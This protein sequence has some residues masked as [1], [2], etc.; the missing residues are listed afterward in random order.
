M[1]VLTVGG[2][3]GGHVTPL[4]YVAS[5]LKKNDSNIEIVY[6]GPKNDRFNDLILSDKNFNLVKTIY[7]G[8]FR[9]YGRSFFA[10][11]TDVSTQLKNLLDLFK[12]S[13]GYVQSL[14]LLIKIKPDVIF[15][16]GSAT[17]VPISYA[18]RLLE[19]KL[20]THDSDHISGLAHKIAGSHATIN[21]VGQKNGN[22]PYPKQRIKYVG[23]PIN[24][25]FKDKPSSEDI[26]KT[27]NKY[28]LKE[29]FV[30][31]LGG[32]LGAEKINNSALEYAKTHD[33]QVVIISGKDNLNEKGLVNIKF[34]SDA[35]EYRNLV[36]LAELVVSRAG[37]TTI[38]ELSA[39]SKPC[40]FIPGSQLVD[41]QMNAKELASEGA[42]II[43]DEASLAS[44]SKEIDSLLTDSSK[45]MQMKKKLEKFTK[46]NAAIQCAE[47]ILD[48]TDE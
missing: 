2:G 43:V 34:I 18:A 13:I 15:S 37:A 26:K 33:T 25:I 40:I 39:S 10:E 36:Y 16:K 44:L 5:A 41:Q 19:V 23:V 42:A 17:S 21:L 7:T 6:V 29:R 35:N 38:T 22:Y 46:H 47:V 4:K 3:S 24:P 30:L 28:D 1:R 48:V 9:R 20:I 11:L 45:K 8:K 31:F 12:L 27:R 14:F 32:S